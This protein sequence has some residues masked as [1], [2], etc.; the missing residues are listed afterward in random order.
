MSNIIEKRT[1]E[2]KALTLLDESQFEGEMS[3]KENPRRLR[4]IYEFDL[5][6]LDLSKLFGGQIFSV[7]AK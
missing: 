2:L 4:E 7:P 6:D 1:A 5:A 3:G